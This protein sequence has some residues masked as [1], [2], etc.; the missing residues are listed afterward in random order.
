MPLLDP[1]RERT[2]ALLRPVRR[3]VLGRRRLL[4]A[5]CVG[6][7][8]LAGV[9]A[10]AAPPPATVDVPVL[11]R[12][13]PA[14]T[15]LR[16]DDVVTAAWSPGT[17]PPGL[18]ADAAGRT[19]ATA[20]ARGEPLTG[21]RLVSADLVRG[22]DGLS[23]MPV[24]FP[25]SAMAALLRVGD[26]IDVVAVDPQGGAPSVVARGVRV[27]ALPAAPAGGVG[28]D[29]LPGRLAVLGTPEADVTA[30]ADASVRLFLTYAYAH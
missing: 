10:T 15:V 7:A 16:A 2:R 25:D 9:R 22:A 12:D 4:A 20:V 17:E 11:A 23:A 28:V 24:R 13:V 30:V 6:V 18:V 14:G 5:A 8:V 19:V 26:R 3:V 29:G 21:T 27:L 1:V